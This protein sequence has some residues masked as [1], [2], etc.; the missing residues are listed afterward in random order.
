M[1]NNPKQA[2]FAITGGSTGTD[3]NGKPTAIVTLAGA[4]GGTYTCS[5]DTAVAAIGNLAE[6]LLLEGCDPN[7]SIAIS[8]NTIP[9][10]I[11][12]V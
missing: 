8:P 6:R 9:D 11:Q 3:A 7:C 1:A 5:G 10:I 12:V 4:S 2:P